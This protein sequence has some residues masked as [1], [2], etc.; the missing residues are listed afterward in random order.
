MTDVSRPCNNARRIFAETRGLSLMA[1]AQRLAAP[2]NP[3]TTLAT[4]ATSRPAHP[5]DPAPKSIV[6]SLIDEQTLRSW[7]R[8]ID[9]EAD[10]N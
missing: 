3:Q 9:E 7:M 1:A 8:G 2:Y 5:T 6:L 10:S 4:P